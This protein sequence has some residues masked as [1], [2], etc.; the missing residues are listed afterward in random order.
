MKTLI[1]SILLVALSAQAHAVTRE[2]CFRAYSAG[3][4]SLVIDDTPTEVATIS[5]SHILQS[6]NSGDVHTI[7]TGEKTFSIITD[8]TMGYAAGGIYLRV[9]YEDLGTQLIGTYELP[10]DGSSTGFAGGPFQA[11]LLNS[12]DCIRP[13]APSTLSGRPFVSTVE[14]DP[15]QIQAVTL[16]NSGYGHSYA[17]DTSCR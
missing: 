3:I 6:P 9:N 12:P 15:R 5:D 1:I 17:P 11:H 16:F 14:A 4:T 8:N 10:A 2:F 7:T 13:Q